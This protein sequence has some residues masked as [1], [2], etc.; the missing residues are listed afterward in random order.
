MADEIKAGTVL[1]TENA[2]LPEAL[3]FE[4][5][6]CV[7]GWKLVKDLNVYTLDRKIREV[8]W[9][10]FFQA[11]E[12]KCTVFGIDGQ[13]MA[14]RAVDRILKDPRAEKFNS[15][16]I[17]RVTSV[18]SARFPGVR[19]LTVAANLRHIQESLF[20]FRAENARESGS[21]GNQCHSSR[22]AV[23]LASNNRLWEEASRQPGVAVVSNP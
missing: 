5:E 8:G 13:Q 18:G 7:S 20:L 12:I 17:A 3:V 9:T 6:S 4:R 11:G 1:I 15:L 16:E 10:F 21:S 14:R 2:L 23:E 22:G 19:F